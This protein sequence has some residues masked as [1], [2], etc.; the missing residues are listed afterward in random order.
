MSVHLDDTSLATALRLR[1]LTDATQG[2]HALQHLVTAA[3]DTLTGIWRRSPS[4]ADAAPDASCRTVT[5]RLPAIVTVADNYASLGYSDDA[6]TR[7]TRYTRYVDGERMLRSHTSAA[8]PAALRGLA[9][10]PYPDNLYVVPGM[11]YRRDSIDRLH[12]G[13]PHQLDLWRIVRTPSMRAEDLRTMI[14]A[15]V[16]ALL[17]GRS[18]RVIPSLHPYTVDGQQIDVHDGDQWVEI[19]ECGLADPDL[20]ARCGLDA[21]WSGLA[22]GLGL[23][24]ILMIRKGVSDIRLLRSDDPRI[25]GQMLDLEPYRPVSMMPPI[26]RDISVAVD[27]GLDEETLGDVVREALGEDADVLESVSVLSCTAIDALPEV[28]RERLGIRPGQ[29]NLLVRMVLR[30]LDRTMTDRDANLLR[31][32]IYRAVHAGDCP[33]SHVGLAHD[34]CAGADS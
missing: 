32:R 29:V 25:A 26:A 27:A 12:T 22:M 8:I 2:P 30:A 14:A 23:D 33:S 7:D 19:G 24:R 11:C 1:D 20:L 16:D 5:I 13:T 17:P 31:D 9:A 18:W 15:L 28:A 10:E 4:P 3:A 6:V 34:E 21:R